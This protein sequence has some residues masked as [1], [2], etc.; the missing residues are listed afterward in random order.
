MSKSFDEW[1]KNFKIKIVSRPLNYAGLIAA[2]TYGAISGSLVGSFG[3]V[4]GML[5]GFFLGFDI[6]NSL[7]SLAES[8]MAQ[9]LN[10]MNSLD[11]YKR[12]LLQYYLSVK[13]YQFQTD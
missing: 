5:L 13:D 10:Q 4:V 2:I 11:K 1:C 7:L 3:M 6:T 9:E 8:D 12:S